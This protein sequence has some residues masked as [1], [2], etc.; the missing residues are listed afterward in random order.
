MT[1]F[2][3]D[4]AV[5][6]E[7]AWS[8]SEFFAWKSVLLNRMNPIFLLGSEGNPLCWGPS[9]AAGRISTMAKG[10][11]IRSFWIPLNFSD[12]YSVCPVCPRA[13]SAKE[14]LI[15]HEL[16]YTRRS[17]LQIMDFNLRPRNLGGAIY[18]IFLHL[19]GLFRFFATFVGW[20][21]MISFGIIVGH[22]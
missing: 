22:Y 2:Q 3:L 8:V 17:F 14:R 7:I 1:V 6:S 20:P 19:P 11:D 16:W 5:F 21:Y 18:L 10:L 15:F 13:W 12:Q 4:G 9:A